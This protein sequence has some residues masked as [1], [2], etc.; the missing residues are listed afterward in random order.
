MTRVRKA[1]K[2]G[3]GRMNPSGNRPLRNQPRNLVMQSLQQKQW[4]RLEE[5]KIQR[6]RE[7][8]RVPPN[9]RKRYGS[10]DRSRPLASYCRVIHQWGC[11]LF[12]EDD[13]DQD[14][15]GAEVGSAPTLKLFKEYSDSKNILQI[16]TFAPIYF[17]HVGSGS[18][19]LAHRSDRPASSRRRAA[20]RSASLC[21]LHR[22]HQLQVHPVYF[23]I[24]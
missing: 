24:F 8:R 14:N 2:V 7:R 10:P 6:R 16:N 1:R 3:R 21:S 15:P 18:R 12:Q 22:P 19:G 4:R 23:F 11:S 9:R 5:R 20:V 13:V 17:C